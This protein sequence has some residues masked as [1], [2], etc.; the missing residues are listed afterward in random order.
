MPPL[1]RELNA[2]GSSP[3]PEAT[4]PKASD[5]DPPSLGF[6]APAAMLLLRGGPE[7]D[8]GLVLGLRKLA[9]W[10][11]ASRQGRVP[12]T[13][14]DSAGEARDV[15]LPLTLHLHLAAYAQH[16]E[17]L[18]PAV[19]AACDDALP[20]AMALTDPAQACAD[21]APAPPL[22]PLT[23]WW[24]LC[25][26]QWAS[27]C[28]RDV[29]LEL[30]DAIVQPILLDPGPEG[31]LHPR[32]PYD[33]VGPG[34]REAS[35]DVWTYRELLGLHAL[36]SLAL[37]RRNRAWARRVQEI[38]Q[39]HARNT[40]PDYTTSQPWALFAFVW[41]A[42]AAHFADQQLHD[43]LSYGSSQGPPGEV[44]LIAALLLADAADCL[45]RFTPGGAGRP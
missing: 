16:Y 19:W 1:R 21:H 22:R 11:A 28:Q 27:L 8:A 13:L 41:S 15:Y 37:L 17:R 4:A 44:S 3:A 42:G 29:D 38:A 35:L 31:S 9:T 34:G 40:Q 6:A 23:L 5:G 18:K 30:A 10:G 39:H 2:P 25:I 14:R 24:A 36:A 7:H 33:A 20:D 12:P 26:A 45:G 32:F 43:A